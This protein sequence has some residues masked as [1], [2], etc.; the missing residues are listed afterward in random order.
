LKQ[1]TYKGSPTVRIRLMQMIK[2]DQVESR[3]NSELADMLDCTP[4]T[5]E[6]YLRDY[7]RSQA[8]DR[9]LS[10]DEYTMPLK[11]TRG[12]K[13]YHHKGCDDCRDC[14]ML[15]KCREEVA[16]GNFVA[17]EVPLA[18]EVY[19]EREYMEGEEDE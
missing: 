11:T 13:L 2:E 15:E 8:G 16:K 3:S 4:R 1:L 18:K 12:M 19:G 9:K 17:C 14:E 5:I 10:T 6:A 7:R